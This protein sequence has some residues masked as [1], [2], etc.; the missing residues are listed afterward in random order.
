MCWGHIGARNYL[1]WHL[2][3]TRVFSTGGS[4]PG[5]GAPPGWTPVIPMVRPVG[6]HLPLVNS[7]DT[8]GGASLGD[9]SAN[10]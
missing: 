6:V 8:P 9:E 10:G 2:G 4:T 1:F 7:M 3:G 5:A